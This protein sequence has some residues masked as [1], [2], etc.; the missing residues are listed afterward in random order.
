M[1]Y[2]SNDN[3]PSLKVILLVHFSL[4][5]KNN[6]L[7]FPIIAYH[8]NLT[9]GPLYALLQVGCSNHGTT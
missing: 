4:S 7:H 9:E 5:I 2:S 3:A 8:S 1:N 6:P